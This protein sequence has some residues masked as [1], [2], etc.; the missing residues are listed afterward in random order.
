MHGI[1]NIDK[2]TNIDDVNII[3]TTSMLKLWDSYASIE[4]YLSCCDENHHT[5]SVTK[6]TPKVLDNER[7]LNYQFLQSYNLTEEQIDEL[8]KPTMDEIEDILGLDYRKS[9]L[10]LK[11]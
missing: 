2:T 8:I 10:F 11:G 5:F 6:V 7:N 3:M 9:I 4:H 1:K